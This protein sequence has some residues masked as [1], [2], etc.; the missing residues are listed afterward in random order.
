M[1]ATGAAGPGAKRVKLLVGE[2]GRSKARAAVP[3]QVSEWSCLWSEAGPGPV[4]QGW[5]GEPDLTLTLAP[6]DAQAVRDGTLAPS[7]AFMQG[8]LKTAG[9]NALLLE[10]LAWT[11][12]PAFSEARHLAA[13]GS[14]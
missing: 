13:T 3:P 12:S 6:A 10:V 4:E 9:D 7:V 1:S 8:R 5:E 14:L 11:T 2:V